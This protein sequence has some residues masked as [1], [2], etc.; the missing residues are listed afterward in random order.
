M[1]TLE[2]VLIFCELYL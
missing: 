2:N 1:Q